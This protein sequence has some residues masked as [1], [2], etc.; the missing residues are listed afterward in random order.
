MFSEFEFMNL[1]LWSNCFQIFRSASIWF[2]ELCLYCHYRS[3]R[4]SYILSL[5]VLCSQLA[6]LAVE[7]P[8]ITMMLLFLIEVPNMPFFCCLLLHLT[9]ALPYAGSW[10][11]W[12]GPK[13]V[14][15][16]IKIESIS[17]L[18]ISLI[19][20]VLHFLIW[21]LQSFN[22]QIIFYGCPVRFTFCFWLKN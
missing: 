11:L 8:F 1:K 16:L 17:C 4:C 6:I 3:G 14:N 21:L 12:V 9:H 7:N 19:Y 20:D 13:V 5:S 15:C 10:E 18:V 22:V 2:V